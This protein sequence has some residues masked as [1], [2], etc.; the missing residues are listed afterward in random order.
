[1]DG[2]DSNQ[3][4]HPR[5]SWNQIPPQKEILDYQKTFNMK[6]C[7]IKPIGLMNKNQ[8]CRLCWGVEVKAEATNVNVKFE[9]R[10]R[11][12]MSSPRQ[13]N[14]VETK[15]RDQGDQYQ[16]RGDQVVEIEMTKLKRRV[17]AEATHV[18]AEEEQ[19]ETKSQGWGDQCKGRG[20]RVELKRKGQDCNSILLMKHE[21]MIKISQEANRGW[22]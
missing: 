20:D 12:P 8:W 14:Q 19:V 21:Y 18:K 13:G 2:D 16:G 15:I 1:M 4:C 10:P 6:L 17:E 9:S 5:K 7:T 22:P 3:D 11:G